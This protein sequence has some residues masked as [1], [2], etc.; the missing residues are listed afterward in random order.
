MTQKSAKK[1]ELNMSPAKVSAAGNDSPGTGARGG[2]NGTVWN[3]ELLENKKLIND[4]IA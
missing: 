2:A 3:E 1:I 4:Q